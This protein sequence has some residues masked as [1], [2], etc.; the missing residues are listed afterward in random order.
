MPPD[1][2]AEQQEEPM[3]LQPILPPPHFFSRKYAGPAGRGTETT[4]WLMV[5]LT[6]LGTFV[7]VAEGDTSGAD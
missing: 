5:M 3:L 4:F 1:Q 2:R 7:Q 6:G